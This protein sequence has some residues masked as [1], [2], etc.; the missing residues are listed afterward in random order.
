M[1]YVRLSA[2]VRNPRSGALT[3][4]DFIEYH[5]ILG[6]FPIEK[7]TQISKLITYS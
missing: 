7:E 4:H 5:L 2:N 3:I 1:R 6:G